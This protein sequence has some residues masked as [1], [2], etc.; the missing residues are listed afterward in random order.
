[1]EKIDEYIKLISEKTGQNEKVV[2]NG[3]LAV[4][5]LVFVLGFGASIVANIVGVLYP[6]FQS[7][8]ALESEQ[9][10]DDKKWLTYWVIFSSF[11]MIDH[12]GEFIL[13]WIPFYFLFKLCFLIYLFLP[14]T[15]GASH[16]YITYVLPFYKK[17]EKDIDTLGKKYKDATKTN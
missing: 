7:F 16:I 2:K 3:I 10:L 4:I 14:A 13:V 8:K 11:S 15:D 12:F 17:Y 5:I 9:G 1:M 6:A